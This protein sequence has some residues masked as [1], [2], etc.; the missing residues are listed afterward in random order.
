MSLY[1]HRI[2]MDKPIGCH[3]AVERRVVDEQIKTNV[4]ARHPHFIGCRNC[5][6]IAWV[7]AANCLAAVN[8][9]G[10]R[11]TLSDGVSVSYCSPDDYYGGNT[12]CGRQ[13]CRRS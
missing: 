8:R 6:P 1:K 10:R 13:A 7:C 9:G 3:E 5:E 2:V 12:A 11:R 4:Y